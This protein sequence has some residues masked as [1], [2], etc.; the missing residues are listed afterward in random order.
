M[1]L[2]ES[3]IGRIISSFKGSLISIDL[4]A[5]SVFEYINCAFTL[6]VEPACL[7]LPNIKTLASNFCEIILA[8]ERC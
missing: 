3:I 7:M 8:K 2:S 5:S 4:I 6:I 1:C